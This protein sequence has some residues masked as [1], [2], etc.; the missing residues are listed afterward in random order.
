MSEPPSTPSVAR[1]P[2]PL[3]S[4]LRRFW[5][6]LFLLCLFGVGVVVFLPAIRAPLLL[7]DVNQAAMARGTYPAPRGPLDLYDFVGPADRRAL[8]DRGVLPWWSDPEIKVRFWRP[9]SS[10]LLWTE[11]RSF[12]GRALPGHLLSLGWWL[13]A[14]IAALTLFCRLFARRAALF[15][16]A[17]FALAPCH[18]VPLAWLA[19]REALVAVTLGIVALIAYLR[20][21][22]RRTIRDGALATALFAAMLATGEYALSITGYVIAI[23]GATRGERIGAR[24]RGLLPF[25]APLAIYLSLHHRLGYGAAGMGFYADPL[26][27]ASTFL[28]TAPA[29]LVALLMTGWLPDGTWVPWWLVVLAP[30]LLGAALWQVGRD[31][32]DAARRPM[33]WMLGGSILALLPVLATVP[34]PRLLGASMIGVAAVVGVILDRALTRRDEQRGPSVLVKLVALALGV[35]HLGYA[36]TVSRQLSRSIEQEAKRFAARAAA[37]RARVA[38]REARE[39]I[40]IRSTGAE[41]TLPFMIDDR[42]ASARRWRVLSQAGH[43]MLLRRDARTLDIV[44]PKGQALFAAGPANLVRKA[45]VPLKVGDSFEVPGMRVTVLDVGP[46]GPRSAR[47]ELDHDLSSPRFAFIVEDHA[48]F[49]DQVL[50]Q[51]GFGVPLDP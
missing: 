15:A 48:G 31:L 22:E 29:R 10:A 20:W 16:T 32:D 37:L 4:A 41:F 47:F 11:Y 39:I 3:R 42:R 36:P 43:L 44:V 19:N 50:P 46:A 8:L 2:S 34:S 25:A 38:G 14:T 1:R 27:E 9:L 51:P 28:H 18:A 21:R 40:V 26:H 12:G 6:P 23:E 24:A 49:H 17:L 30:L 45:H 5:W 33:R 35:V 7:D 13:G